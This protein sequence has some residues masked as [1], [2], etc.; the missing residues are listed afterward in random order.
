MFRISPDKALLDINMIHSYLSKESYW[1]KNIPLETVIRS[2]DN[3]LCFGVYEDNKQI[4][5]ARV[6]TD[7]ATF[8]YLADVFILPPYR[9]KGLSKQ[10]IS[11]IT[12]YP[13]LQGLRRWMLATAD[14]HGLY[15]QFGFS[16]LNKPERMMEISRTNIYRDL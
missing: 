2:V 11:F 9:G 3:S 5:F 16:E 4:G 8:A 13:S 7:N 1:A 14:A 15:R 6:I 12:N 10:L